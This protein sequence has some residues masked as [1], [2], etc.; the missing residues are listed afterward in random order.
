MTST[1]LLIDRFRDAL[2]CAVDLHMA[3]E[4][5][6]TKVPYVGHLLGV[7]AWVLADGGDEDEAIAALLHDA[8]EDHPDKISAAEIATR[9]GERVADLVVGC[10]DTP[11]DYQGGAKPPWRSRKESY[12]AHIARLGHPRC[13]VAL[14]DKLDNMR[15]ILADYRQLGDRL[16]QRFNAGKDEQL[17]FYRGSVTAFRAAGAQGLMFDEFERTV[18]EL[19]KLV[20]RA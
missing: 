13:R 9:F 18:H 3:D 16:W 8:L 20:G 19:E 2:V 7:C 17:W 10:T 6:G 15:A 1:K 11:P 5:K 14:A 4:R 12:L